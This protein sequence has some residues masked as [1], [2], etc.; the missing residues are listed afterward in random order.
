MVH[1]HDDDAESTLHPVFRQWELAH[2]EHGTETVWT[3]AY[4]CTN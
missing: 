4:A 3:A 2:L 1:A